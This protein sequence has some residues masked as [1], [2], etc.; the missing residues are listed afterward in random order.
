[1]ENL[2]RTLKLFQIATKV[3]SGAPV[4]MVRSIVR[5]IID[6]HLV[7]DNEDCVVIMSLKVRFAVELSN[8]FD[9]ERD[10]LG[11]LSAGQV[12]SFLDPRYKNVMAESDLDKIQIREAIK[13]EMS[14]SEDISTSD[15]D[16]TPLK[17]SDLDFLFQVASWVNTVDGQLAK[18]LTE[19]QIDHNMDP[20]PW[21]KSREGKYPTLGVLAKKYLAI[22][23]T[24]TS[25]ERLFSAAGN[26]VTSKIDVWPLKMSAFWFFCIKIR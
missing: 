6:K 14:N 19:P 8:R 11:K 16:D 3:L 12:P 1:M 15:E 18:Y 25:S 20:M 4:S 21:W 22:P 10:A 9:M 13:V 2:L 24:S 17:G 23:A 7:P 5:S 26:I